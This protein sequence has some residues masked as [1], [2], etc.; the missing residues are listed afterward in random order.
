MVTVSI[1]QFQDVA[2][3]LSGMTA[4]IVPVI[5]TMVIVRMTPSSPGTILY[6]LTP[7]GL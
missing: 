6:A 7:A 3:V 1:I 2:T 4:M 5:M